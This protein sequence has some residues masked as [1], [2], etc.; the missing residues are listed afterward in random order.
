M[1]ALGLKLEYPP[2]VSIEQTITKYQKG[3]LNSEQLGKYGLEED[4]QHKD[5]SS[6]R[7]QLRFTVAALRSMFRVHD[8][9]GRPTCWLWC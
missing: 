4:L 2:G 9:P 7:Q 8:F 1:Q 5:R 3:T 6:G